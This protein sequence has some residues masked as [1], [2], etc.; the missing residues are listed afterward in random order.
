M[1]KGHYSILR[2]SHLS[3]IGNFSIEQ[4]GFHQVFGGKPAFLSNFTDLL[5][6]EEI[7][8]PQ[9]LSTLIEVISKMVVI[10]SAYNEYWG[11]RTKRRHRNM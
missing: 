4:W 9:L 8:Y 10:A 6:S 3:Q 1:E 5:A 11:I 7:N 2:V